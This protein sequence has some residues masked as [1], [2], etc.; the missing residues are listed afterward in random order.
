MLSYQIS[1]LKRLLSY[2]KSHEFKIIFQIKYSKETNDDVVIQKEKRIIFTTTINQARVLS[3][4]IDDKYRND[5]TIKEHVFI[6]NEMKQVKSADI[7][8]VISRMVNGEENQMISDD[9]M[10][11]CNR[12]ISIF[13]DEND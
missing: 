11:L 3:K 7:I 2:D 10:Y 4:V 1:S 13:E 12:M 9:K 5:P 8:D 6:I